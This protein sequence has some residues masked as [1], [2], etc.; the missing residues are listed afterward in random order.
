MAAIARH[1]HREH[2]RIDTMP[3]DERWVTSLIKEIRQLGG[4]FK[5]NSADGGRRF[6]LPGGQTVSLPK[7]GQRDPAVAQSVIRE[8]RLVLDRVRIASM[9]K[10]DGLSRAASESEPVAPVP[11]IEETP[12]V[13]PVPVVLPVSPPP[14]AIYPKVPGADGLIPC[15]V[16]DC[17]YRYRL[18]QAIAR[19]RQAIHGIAGMHPGSMAKQARRRASPPSDIPVKRVLRELTSLRPDVITLPKS[20]GHEIRS[21]FETITNALVAA[22]GH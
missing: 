18:P 19:H 6:K 12:G 20:I 5:T 21:L 4:S 8:V 17:I 10:A 13:L 11:A 9:Q 3:V 16:G 1:R 14:T 2:E 7:R 15:C 22:A